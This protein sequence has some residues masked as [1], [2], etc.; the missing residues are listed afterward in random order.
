M[1]FLL[2]T[3][4]HCILYKFTY[5]LFSVPVITFLKSLPSPL[6]P[7]S[8]CWVI[9]AQFNNLGSSHPLQSPLSL[10]IRVFIFLNFIRKRRRTILFIPPPVL[11]LIHDVQKKCHGTIEQAERH[12]CRMPRYETR[13]I[14]VPICLRGH[15]TTAI[16]S[17]EDES[18]ANGLLV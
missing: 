5:I 9:I 17:G 6:Q 15:D 3:R 14:L 8:E 7:V 12:G 18:H 16:T 4:F 2:L 13:G 10:I 1:L 11:S